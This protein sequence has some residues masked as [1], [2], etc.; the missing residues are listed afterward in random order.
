[1]TF[2]ERKVAAVK[3]TN[4]LLVLYNEEIEKVTA[5]LKNTGKLE[6]GLDANS[7][8]YAP[9]NKEFDRRCAEIFAKYNLPPGTKLKLW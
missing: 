8:A 9:V 5:E 3:E 4:D 7:E 6:C 2:E 1:M